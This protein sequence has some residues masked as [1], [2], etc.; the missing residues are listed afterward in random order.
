M[1]A[2]TKPDETVPAS[3]IMR[4]RNEWKEA[5]AA[6]LTRAE[7]AER[8]LAALQYARTTIDDLTD[9]CAA[10]GAYI[11]RLQTEVDY[12]KTSAADWQRCREMADGE[13]D[14]L[15]FR[16]KY[17]TTK[18]RD[19]LDGDA[20]MDCPACEDGCGECDGFGRVAR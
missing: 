10:Q 18:L 5:W 16:E 11:Q 14:R 1:S 15:K 2:A 3:R 17:L 4:E 9:H 13:I 7:T 20:G 12:W 6:Q 19:I 8:E